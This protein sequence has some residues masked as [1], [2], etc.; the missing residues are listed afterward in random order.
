MREWTD[1]TGAYHIKAAFESQEDAK[2]KL[3]REDGK[4]IVMP[5][6]KLS[7]ADQEYLK[8][9]ANDNPF[10]TGLVDDDAQEGSGSGKEKNDVSFA[11]KGKTLK[12][13]GSDQ[14]IYLG[15]FDKVKSYGAVSS[16]RAWKVEPSKKSSSPSGEFRNVALFPRSFF[17]DFSLIYSHGSVFYV[18]YNDNSKIGE[19][20]GCVA[21]CDVSEG[22]CSR[23]VFQFEAPSLFDVS[24]DGKLALTNIKI[25]SNDPLIRNAFLAITN[26][27]SLENG[28]ELA[29]LAVFCPY[30]KPKAN[31]YSRDTYDEVENA[32]FVDSDHIFTKCK[33]AATLWNIKSCRAEYSINCQNERLA[34]DPAH[35]YFVL[36]SGSGLG[37]Y[38]VA[39]GEALGY[40]EL[41][42]DSGQEV[43]S[44]ALATSSV[45][46]SPNGEKL[47]FLI[48][49][50][51]FIVDLKSGEITQTLE[52]NGG[53]STVT[54][55]SDSHVLV[56]T[57]CYD[58]ATGA[59][60][61][62]YLG[63][64]DRAGARVC[65]GDRV[66]TVCDN[67]ALTALKLPHAQALAA[68]KG[69]RLSD[70]FD[71]YPGVG[72]SIKCDLNGL[73]DEGQTIER[74]K[75]QLAISGLKYDPSSK[76]VVV[77]S[78][79]DTGKTEETTVQELGLERMFAHSML[80][81]ERVVSAKTLNLKVF[82]QSISLQVGGKE[83]VKRVKLTTG[84]M[85]GERDEKKT[86]DEQIQELNKPEIDFYA[87][88]P[89][90]SY[91]SKADGR[92]A[93]TSAKVSSKGVEPIKF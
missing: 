15:S 18:G 66:W 86:F 25:K 50:R 17:G 29:P 71:V 20:R 74:V 82:E 5:I 2:V 16:P 27:G 12:L 36:A 13:D 24:E 23:A 83:V 57:Y 80:A 28:D 84:P 75:K 69:K 51:A 41:P 93:A 46:F 63:L 89:I 11:L 87:V 9:L 3:R 56:G 60:I 58:L 4:R 45:A 72:V 61:A 70:L 73:L 30:Y 77:A 88:M 22:T 32:F 14:K 76:I 37:F 43:G 52:T 62:Y 42:Q 34:V 10:E 92:E 64:P 55:A 26:V 81:R 85:R 6:S 48:F 40:V 90:P 44:F 53:F 33:S 78:A 68:V 31:E 79:S 65:V 35:K 1:S 8:G 21:R 54:W 39:T 7:D 49:R 19:S 59:P 91:A 67:S 38:D 47:A